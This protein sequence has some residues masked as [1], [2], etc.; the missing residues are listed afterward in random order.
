MTIDYI[1]PFKYL[2]ENP[3][4]IREILKCTLEGTAVARYVI[5][6]FESL[7]RAAKSKTGQHEKS[8]LTFHIMIIR[9][10]RYLD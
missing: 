3:L 9:M 10:V 8:K 5:N 6:F 4:I 1:D 7:L 2:D